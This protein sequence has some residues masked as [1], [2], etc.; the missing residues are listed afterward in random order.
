MK[1]VLLLGLIVVGCAPAVWDKPGA[2]EAALHVDRAACETGRHLVPQA[3][4]QTFPTGPGSDLGR[5]GSDPLPSDAGMLGQY[6]NEC[7]QAKGWTQ[8]FR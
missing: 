7:L 1:P 6:I 2:T 8:V 5:A 4:R 3:G